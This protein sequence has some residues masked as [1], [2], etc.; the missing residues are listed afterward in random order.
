MFSDLGLIV[1]KRHEHRPTGIVSSN[2]V[3]SSFFFSFFFLTITC[4]AAKIRQQR[5]NYTQYMSNV[6]LMRYISSTVRTC[7]FHVYLTPRVY[8]CD[9]KLMITPG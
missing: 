2:W 9:M 1:L 4:Q 3:R 6:F 7:H 8:A 5:S